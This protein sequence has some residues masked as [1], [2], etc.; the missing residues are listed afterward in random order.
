LKKLTAV[1]L[2]VFVILTLTV[3]VHATDAL[4]GKWA[5]TGGTVMYVFDGSG[6]GS[7]SHAAHDHKITYTVD[8]NKLKISFP[9]NDGHGLSDTFTFEV[10][11]GLLK[12]TIEGKTVAQRYEK[13]ADD[14]TRPE[15]TPGSQSTPGDIGNDDGNDNGNGNML[16]WLLIGGTGGALVT[17]V[18]AFVIF[19]KKIKK[20]RMR[21]KSR[22]MERQIP[23]RDYK[24]E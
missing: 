10:D 1:L 6:G 20:E 7:M 23:S 18:I 9:D 21:T 11:G 22:T 16:L 14:W 8:G 4:Q 19:K 3:S 13:K 24:N 5:N 17:F 2:T 12:L 15:R